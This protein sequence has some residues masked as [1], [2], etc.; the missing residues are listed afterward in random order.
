MIPLVILSSFAVPQPVRARWYAQPLQPQALSWPAGM[1]LFG[2]AEPPRF[3]SVGALMACMDGLDGAPNHFAADAQGVRG[4]LLP[5]AVQ[6]LHQ[7]LACALRQLGSLG[8]RGTLAFLVFTEQIGFVVEQDGEGGTASW[9]PTSEIFA[10]EGLARAF[11]IEME[12]VNAWDRDTS[13]TRAAF[14]AAQRDLGMAS[15]ESQPHH[16]DVLA[17][18]D[19]VPAGTLFECMREGGVT[20]QHDRPLHELYPDPRALAAAVAAREPAVRA[21][22]IEL[23]TLID[24]PA[25][26]ALVGA[27]VND[28]S[29]HVVRHAIRALGRMRSDAAFE[30]L[31]ELDPRRLLGFV[32]LAFG[33]ALEHSRAPG[34][35]RILRAALEGPRLR[36]AAWSERAPVAD[37]PA[38]ERDILHA[39]V[40]IETSAIRRLADVEVPLFAIFEHHPVA[41]VRVAAASALARLGGSLAQSQQLPLQYALM[42]MGKALNQDDERRAAL[43][44]VDTKD[45]STGIVRLDLDAA[46]LQALL[47]EGFT[48]P[49]LQQNDAPSVG[50]F[51][52]MAASHPELRF[53]GY[54]VPASRADYRISLD[55]VR[56][57]LDAVPDDRRDEVAALFDELSRSATNCDAAEGELACW[58]T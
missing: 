7:D 44:G 52:G 11:M 23:L 46:T 18:L 12:F 49:S 26:E 51:A 10:D 40:V 8:V 45:E 25:G 35:E 27:I 28:D 29:E 21:A 2:G 38:R 42:G 32:Q 9:R 6:E 39:Q 4:F 13:L 34:A 20:G 37:D 43:C 58:W 17:R 14:L 31:L 30:R 19:A 24:E 57:R 53:G 55:A 5:D 47:D 16:E 1:P 33:R 56:V 54:A 15:I 48:H 36:P 41:A 22:A 50:Q 3:D